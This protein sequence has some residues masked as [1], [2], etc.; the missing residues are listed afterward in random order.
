MASLGLYTPIRAMPDGLSKEGGGGSPHPVPSQSTMGA[1]SHWA[2]PSHVT[3]L[4]L[5]KK[6]PRPPPCFTLMDDPV[7]SPEAQQVID[8]LRTLLSQLEKDL[9]EIRFKASYF[10]LLRLHSEKHLSRNELC[11]LT[12]KNF[13]RW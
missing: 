7:L 3:L 1:P 9:E 6:N 5:Y 4:F 13:Y 10:E 11:L 8:R 12:L 2:L